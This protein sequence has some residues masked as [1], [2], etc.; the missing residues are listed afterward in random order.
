MTPPINRPPPLTEEERI[1]R[2]GYRD[3]RRTLPSGEVVVDR[4][5]LTLEDLLHPQEGDVAVASSLHHHEKHYLASVFRSQLADDTKALVLSNCGICWDIPTLQHHSPDVTVVLNVRAQRANWP[6]F[7]VAEEGTRPSLIVEI[8]S[9]SYRENDVETKVLQYHLAGVPWYII[10]DREKEDDT[11]RLIVRRHQS[12]G[13][14]VV[15]LNEKGHIWL[16]MVRVWLGIQDGKIA[17]FDADTG[18]RFGDYAEE[19]RKLDKQKARIKYLESQLEAINRAK[20]YEA[21]IRETEARANAEAARANVA[22]ETNRSLLERLAKIEAE[23]QNDRG[24]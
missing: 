24:V 18:D 6:I 20:R 5:A 9:P 1:Q 19:C 23:L 21:Q 15:P 2:Y 10:V 7:R 16:P 4:I 17:C 22:E 12:D 11:P 3:V 8:V 13:W 14:E